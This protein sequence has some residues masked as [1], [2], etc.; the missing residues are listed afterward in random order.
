MSLRILLALLILGS[1]ANAAER[2]SVT[3][4]VT[5]PP[6]TGN[7]L[8]INGATR[9]WT[10]ASSSTT[11]LTN[12]ASVNGSAT[13]LYN[14]YA[15]FRIGGGVDIKWIETN[16][17]RFISPFGTPISGSLVG[18]T[19]ASLVIS[20]QS[21]PQTFDAAWPME[22]L[23]GETNRTNQGSSLVYGL[24]IYSTNAF[25][26][27]ATA[28]SNYITKGASAGQ[29][30]SAPLT[31]SSL[32]MARLRT[33]G[34]IWF[35]NGPLNSASYLT[36]DTNGYPVLRQYTG[37]ALD[38]LDDLGFINQDH[39]LT[40]QVANRIF[41]LKSTNFVAGGFSGNY[42]FTENTWSNSA[43]IF[44]LGFLA[45]NAVLHSSKQTNATTMGTAARD[46]TLTGT[47]VINGR[48]DLIAGNR[49]TLANGYNSGTILGTNV[50]LRMSGPSAAYTNAGFAAAVDGSWHKLQFD[51]PGLSYTILDNSGL[52]AVAA[53]RIL[54]GTGGLI[55]STNNPV[56]VEVI[57]DAV[58]TKW[59]VIAFR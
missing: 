45:T 18:G 56:F 19:W 11:I 28:T 20:T 16:Q 23:V 51:N 50:Y 52:D 42:W 4:T 57:Y 54:T 35:T 21:G 46:S 17:V 8:V 31:I 12:L 30:I 43:N 41:P 15:N 44:Q 24:G 26:T 48:I 32:T 55:N 14:D 6:V 5:N 40:L 29:T 7:G 13:N 33:N 47:N 2:V 39:I 27:N 49:T 3:V 38:P 25:P 9:T 34:S 58:N 1:L 22:N 36:A 59:R 53:N 10:N 37:I